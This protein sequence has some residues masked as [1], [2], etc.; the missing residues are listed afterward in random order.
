MYKI[1]TMKRSRVNGNNHDR[2]D[3]I[4]VYVSR[5]SGSWL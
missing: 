5:N 1:Q 4:Y 3:I 2:N